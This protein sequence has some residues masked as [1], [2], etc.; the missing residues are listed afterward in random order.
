MSLLHTL[1][2]THRV[3]ARHPHDASLGVTWRLLRVLMRV[4]RLPREEG[5][6]RAVV[7]VKAWLKKMAWSGPV[8][9]LDGTSAMS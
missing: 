1:M 2:A 9:S 8:R 5:M 6:K 3:I 7:G 4:H